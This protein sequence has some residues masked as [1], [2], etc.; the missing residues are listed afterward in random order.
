MPPT[1]RE[2]YDRVRRWQARIGDATVFDDRHLDEV[3][4]FFISCHHLKDWLKNDRTLDRV[5]RD[6]AESLVNSDDWLKLCADVANGAKHLVISRT[7]RVAPGLRVGMMEWTTLID[8]ANAEWEALREPQ[9]QLVPVIHTE[10]QAVVPA[11]HAAD[12]CVRVWETFLRER[13]L[14]NGDA[15]G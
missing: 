7:I 4:A 15:T 14:L 13:G 12:E 5:I 3:N 6:A 2:Q 1:W 11:L 10:W 9:V 8:P